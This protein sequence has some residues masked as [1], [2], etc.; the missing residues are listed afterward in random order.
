MEATT[1]E[2]LVSDD[3]YVR[4]LT[5]NRPH[6]SNALSHE[7][8]ALMI[9]E[10]IRADDDPQVRAIV[11]VGA[12]ERAFCAGADLK[13]ARARDEAGEPF[14]LPMRGANR[15]LF[16]VVLECNTPTIAAINGHAVGGG[17][18]LA[19]SCDLRVASRE[20]TLTMTE[21]K[22]GMGA[23]FGSVV[24]PRLFPM[25]IA[26]EL[27][28]TAEPMTVEDAARW[29]FINRVVAPDEVLS[30][31]QELAAKIAGNAPVSVRRMKA[32]AITGIGL[33][34][35]AA[36]RLDLGPNPYLSEDRQE[37]IQAFVE[38]REPKWKGR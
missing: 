2:V 26:L 28:L 32:M 3:G 4:T 35:T 6:R 29:G 15:N 33:P 36:L 8:S 24:L 38:K 14:R 34:I 27:L 22:R 30:T 21:A 11:I 37:G 1:S 31:A 7:V 5:I 18:E 20:A 10:V 23:N 12:G 25:P 19:A 16:E 9:E 17:F 13:D